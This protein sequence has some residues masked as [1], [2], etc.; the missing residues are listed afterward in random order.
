MIHHYSKNG[1]LLTI[2]IVFFLLIL[3]TG[4][5]QHKIGVRAGGNISSLNYFFDGEKVEGQ[6][7]VLKTEFGVYAEKKIFLNFHY[8]LEFNYFQSGISLPEQEFQL[9]A[10]SI[11]GNAILKYDILT[12]RIVPSVFAGLGINRNLQ[13]STEDN[14]DR[15][16]LDEDQI[17]ANGLKKQG[18]GGV[19]GIRLAYKLSDLSV[20]FDARYKKSF[21]NLSDISTEDLDL[22]I[23]KQEIVLGLGVTIS[24]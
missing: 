17:D 7:S 14:P 23:N 4:Y 21:T 13:V 1:S 18:F 20:F 5:G 11:E 8:C 6:E 10:T 2:L 22:K 19:A 15:N 24:I 3:N 12:G 9:N 16:L